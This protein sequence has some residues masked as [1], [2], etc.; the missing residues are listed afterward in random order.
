MCTTMI[1]ILSNY[2]VDKVTAKNIRK[3]TNQGIEILE[4]KKP[5]MKKL[6]QI[7]LAISQIEDKLKAD[8]E[9]KTAKK[10]K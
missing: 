5:D 2:K 6:D 10:D 7:V 8:K 1:S 9:E 4:S 3:L